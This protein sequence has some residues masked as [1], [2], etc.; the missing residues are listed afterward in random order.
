[1]PS[2]DNNDRAVW[3]RQA[4][5]AFWNTQVTGPAGDNEEPAIKVQDL[6]SNLQHLCDAWA[7]DWE[8][9]TSLASSMYAAEISED[10]GKAQPLT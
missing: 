10:G 8:I 5:E 2:P 4:V 1:M 3:G 7:I 6:L 9:V